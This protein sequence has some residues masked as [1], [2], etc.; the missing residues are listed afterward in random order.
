[1]RDIGASL[2]SDFNELAFAGVVSG[3]WFAQSTGPTVNL[4]PG[5]ELLTTGN[6]G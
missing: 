2:N 6:S 4:I 3:L 5:S 1:M